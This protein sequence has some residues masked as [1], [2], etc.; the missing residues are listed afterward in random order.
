MG[1]T[2]GIGELTKLP[3]EGRE[4]HSALDGVQ[5]KTKR[6]LNHIMVV[7]VFVFVFVVCINISM[8]VWGSQKYD[9]TIFCF[10]RST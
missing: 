5:K 6:L 2:M 7:V 10:V 4:L 3:P 9:Y 8:R 1:K